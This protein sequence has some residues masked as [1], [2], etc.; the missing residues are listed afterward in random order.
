MSH[1]T[2][3]VQSTLWTDVVRDWAIDIG[4]SLWLSIL[5]VGAILVVYMVVTLVPQGME[6]AETLK[7]SGLGTNVL[8]ACCWI[9]FALALTFA[10]SSALTTQNHPKAGAQAFP[11][12]VLIAAI[13]SIVPVVFPHVLSFQWA[14]T[15]L[16]IA[17]L[18]SFVWA[19]VSRRFGRKVPTLYPKRLSVLLECTVLVIGIAFGLAVFLWPVWFP[20][21]VGVVGVVYAGMA[22]WAYTLTFLCIVLPRRV[23]LPAL[24]LVPLVIIL[25]CAQWND[26]H[27]FRGCQQLVVQSTQAVVPVCTGGW[28]QVKSARSPQTLDDHVISWMKAHCKPVTPQQP[29]SCPMIF[30]AAEGGGSRAAYFTAQL[31]K[32]LDDLTANPDVP[33]AQRRSRDYGFFQHL[34]AV[35]SVSGGTVG[36][37]AYLGARFHDGPLSSKALDDVAGGEFLSPIIAGLLF[38]E[39]VQRFWPQPI[40]ALDRSHYFELGLERTWDAAY[41]DDKRLEHDFLQFWSPNQEQTGPAIFINTTNVETGAPVVFSNLELRS[42]EHPRSYYAIHREP[43][44]EPINVASLPMSAAVHLSSRFS[45][46]NPPATIRSMPSAAALEPLHGQCST[47]SSDIVPWGR[48]VD[49]GYYDNS[50]SETLRDV[51]IATHR[52]YLRWQGLRQNCQPSPDLSEAARRAS[53]APAYCPIPYIIPQYIVVNAINGAD[54][55]ADIDVTS[56]D[57]QLPDRPVEPAR[58]SIQKD[59]QLRENWENRAFRTWYLHRRFWDHNISYSDLFGPLAAYGNVGGSHSI[60][61]QKSLLTTA[62]ALAASTVGLCFSRLYPGIDARNGA[63]QAAVRRNIFGFDALMNCAPDM[64]AGLKPNDSWLCRLN[65]QEFF[66]S[67]NELINLPALQTLFFYMATPDAAIMCQGVANAYRYSFATVEKN[68]VLYKPEAFAS[69]ALGWAL[70]Q[71]SKDS[72][73]DVVAMAL[74]EP[75]GPADAVPLPQRLNA[76]WTRRTAPR[77]LTII[78]ADRNV[79][80]AIEIESTVYYGV[81]KNTRLPSFQSPSQKIERLVSIF[82]SPLPRFLYL[83]SFS[84]CPSSFVPQT[85]AHGA[86]RFYRFIKS[87]TQSAPGYDFY[88][89]PR[90]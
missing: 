23:G 13:G 38:Q 85:L 16:F 76:L 21:T 87:K 48:L 7:A 28:T 19:G 24:T 56:E 8:S 80:A 52:A 40:N 73:H 20:R 10:S 59:E 11:W 67:H 63:F 45:Y 51:L 5:P 60:A 71:A 26:N 64:E 3:P 41:A 79:K 36:S 47:C 75:A 53:S 1:S 12:F 22:F 27:E 4:G 78:V 84:T 88:C 15:L 90:R 44:G 81:S 33:K 61:A 25:I 6:I 55:S 42:Q 86:A 50:G 46:V 72:I 34:F 65:A 2:A 62:N 31:L 57:S 43:L 74:A 29:G 18:L 30:V 83:T 82:V 32:Q 37:V 70:S 58:Q 35:S 66:P 68:L 69:P 49:G 77:P 9:Y 14:L 39:M 17:L 54:I 89:V